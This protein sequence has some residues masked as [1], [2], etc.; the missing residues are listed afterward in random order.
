[1]E[2][3]FA[4]VSVGLAVYFAFRKNRAEYEPSLNFA[5]SLNKLDS[6]TKNLEKLGEN[7]ELYS[8][9]SSLKKLH[10]LRLNDSG[11]A[12][13]KGSLAKSTAAQ[14]L[15]KCYYP[16]LKLEYD[17]NVLNDVSFVLIDSVPSSTT[18]RK[19]GYSG[20]RYASDRLPMPLAAG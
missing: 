12:Y 18:R 19:V 14:Q 2:V 17:T 10:S 16:K 6:V 5:D 1:M 9:L 13:G 15:A 3:I 7:I 20:N 4:F 11:S 8:Q